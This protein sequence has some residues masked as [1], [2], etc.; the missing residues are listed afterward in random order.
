M[1]ALET[2][3]YTLDLSRSDIKAVALDY[4]GVIA[5]M[6]SDDNFSRLAEKAEVPEEVLSTPYWNLRVSYDA[7]LWDF[8]TYMREV[9]T[10]CGSPVMKSVDFAE[11]FLLDT[12]SYSH[13]RTGI[14]RWIEKMKEK[15]LTFII[16]SNI[17]QEAAELL[18]EKSEWASLF[19]H[20]IYSGAIRS[21]K[22]EKAIYEHAKSLLGIDAPKV[23]FIDDR[24]EN[25]RAAV[26]CGFSGAL[27]V[28]EGVIR[29]M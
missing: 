21:C 5:D 14:I 15:G 26:S 18:I 24:E 1:T 16:I 4:G 23:L 10:C 2:D 17:G 27:M 19:D 22:P 8:N 9:L 29:Q 13:T 7:G 12:L 20:R 3:L 28:R 6:I 25:V 11:L